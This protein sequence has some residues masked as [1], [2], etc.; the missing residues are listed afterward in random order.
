MCALTA[1]ND[2]RSMSSSVAG[3]TRRRISAVTASTAAWTSVNSAIRVARAGGFGTR[4]SVIFVIIASVPSEPTSNCVRSYPTTFFTAFD[5]V[6]MISP[7]G[8]T[9]SSAST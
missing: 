4:R 8:N 6:S 7:F 1:C 3:T 9:A 5:P 2:S